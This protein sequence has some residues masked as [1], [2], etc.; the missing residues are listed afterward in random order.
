M[1]ASDFQ[2]S[3]AARPALHDRLMMLSS[4]PLPDI[5]DLLGKKPKIQTLR[6]GSAAAPVPANATTAFTS[7]SDLLR[8]ARINGDGFSDI[9]DEPEFSATKK[10]PAQR[11]KKAAKKRA[12]KRVAKEVI[13]LSS[14]GVTPQS[15]HQE[16]T[17][18]DAGKLEESAGLGINV[19]HTPPVQSK[20]REKL[21]LSVDPAQAEMEAGGA[22]PRKPPGKTKARKKNN[23]LEASSKPLPKNSTMPQKATTA[24]RPRALTPEPMN[25]EPAVQRRMDWTPPRPDTLLSIPDSL[26]TSTDVFMS[27]DEDKNGDAGDIFRKLHQKYSHKETDVIL[28]ASSKPQAVPVL[29][30]RK[31]IELVSVNPP[32]ELSLAPPPVK[33]KAPKKKPRTITE[34]A[35]AAYA[36]KTVDSAAELRKEDSL[37][38]YFS[39][40]APKEN[41][42]NT[43]I[44]NGKGKVSKVTKKTKKKN[45]PKQPVLLSPQAAMRQSAAQDFVF[46]T[47]SQLAREQSPTFLKDLHAALRA[48]NIASDGDPFA[49]T[50]D[51]SGPSNTKKGGRG[52]W[53]VSARDE[54]GALVDIEVIDL[55]DSPAFPQDDAILNP[56]K[57]L[58][59]EPAAMGTET[60]DSSVVEIYSRTLPTNDDTDSRPP[61]PKFTPFKTK[62][63]MTINSIAA[64]SPEPSR[65]SYPL[66]T[67]LL[68]DDIPP[69]SN[70]EQTKEIL[71]DPSSTMAAVS[72]IHQSRPKIE[73]FTDAKLAK[74]ISRYGFKAV[75][76]RT[77]MIA[78]LDQCWRSKNQAPRAR[79]AFSTTSTTPSPKANKITSEA[80][81]LPNTISPAKRPRGRPKKTME[82]S[83]VDTEMATIAGQ[84]ETVSGEHLV[85]PKRKRGRPR[86]DETI[87]GKR[88]TSPV[89]PLRKSRPAVS[90]P[91]RKKAV[92]KRAA[93][94]MYSDLD[95][96]LEEGLTS[97]EQLF[98]PEAADV[99][100]SEDTEISLNVSPT[101][102]Q[103]ALFSHITKAVT[104]APRT[105]DPSNPSWHEMMLMYD[106][107]DIEDLTVWLNSGQLTRCGYD[108]E[109]TPLE[110]KKWCESRSICCIWKV[111]LRGK[112]RKRL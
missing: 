89:P 11:V 62:P 48:S 19:E 21:K 74:E 86:K 65:S 81:A 90:T 43:V 8:T 105:T 60:A 44:D 69:P 94:T 7:A 37:L 24:K 103:S 110:V 83:P 52:L 87:A 108:G 18:T 55:V 106:P 77:A 58:P 71:K 50:P 72:P 84:N 59:P 68:E 109:I 99:S 112:E 29:G 14:D 79:S 54:D 100:I 23:T 9:I 82:I 45:P 53:S 97:P 27:E 111:N 73:L 20:S 93:E 70:Q 64:A 17:G 67:D 2:S 3:P 49:C 16:S 28:S 98:S 61:V 107:I 35:T 46:G 40:G 95:S 13:V 101:T 26:D 4:S 41:S 1:A 25:L 33:E 78:L 47:S 56:W 88:T 42:L 80:G 10:A 96:D 22:E 31:A 57:D 66:I 5:H 38:E 51:K 102:Q 32:P 76:T 34:L 91:K 104:S 85:T 12:P 36:A 92:T 30:K 63:K 39:P 75:K 15:P 6:S